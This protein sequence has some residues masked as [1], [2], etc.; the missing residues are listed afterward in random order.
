MMKTQ[1]S[2]RRILQCGVSLLEMAIVLFVL[3]LMSVAV[4]SV[5]QKGQ[6][7]TQ[8]ITNEDNLVS[9]ENAL[10]GYALS[11]YHLPPPENPVPSAT[12]P[13]FTEGW[14]PVRQ[15]G[16]P[17]QRIRYLVDTALL[18]TPSTLYQVDPLELAGS[19]IPKRTTPNGLD[20]CSA[21]MLQEHSGLALPDGRK[22]GFAI[23]KVPSYSAETTHTMW[24]GDVDEV[25]HPGEVQQIT[26]TA[27]YLEA[28]ARLNCVPHM[29]N[30]A[31]SVRSTVTIADLLKLAEQG[32]AFKE[33][34][35]KLAKESVVN[36]KWRMSVWVAGEASMGIDMIISVI[37]AQEGPYA[38]ASLAITEAALTSIIIGTGIFLDQ[39]RKGITAG[40][41]GVTVAESDRDVAK[42]YRDKLNAQL[43]AISNQTNNL[44]KAGLFP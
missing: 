11:E 7:S 29:A 1:L 15:L 25:A 5:M 27:G 33:L 23:Q 38:A 39:T 19:H 43:A 28:M 4:V 37:Q 9:A 8:T 10:Y 21:L 18:N 41:A 6:Q 20:F 36:K 2:P 13:G 14:L 30:L 32:V 44:Q 16:L 3:G 24:L 17:N 34:S 22:L 35:L 26:R 31:A 42:A 40:E 12:R